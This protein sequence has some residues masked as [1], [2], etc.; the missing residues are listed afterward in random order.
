MQRVIRQDFEDLLH[1]KRGELDYLQFEAAVSLAFGATAPGKPG[2]YFDI[3]AACMAINLALSPTFGR[4]VVTTVVLKFSAMIAAII[5]RAEV[6]RTQDSFLGIGAFGVKDAV[7][8]IPKLYGVT[9]GTMGELQE[10]F[11][12]HDEPLKNACLVNVSDI[13]RR[14]RANAREL[15]INLEG[16]FFYL[17]DDPRFADIRRVVEREI[18]ARIGRLKADKKKLRWAKARRDRQDIKNLS[19]QA[20]TYPFEMVTA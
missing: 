7:R 14:L 5:A 2:D 11:Q 1:L 13:L 18:E 8:K 6:D 3:D 17:S 10:D 4:D 15:G 16:E 9:A 19:R 12:G 20:A